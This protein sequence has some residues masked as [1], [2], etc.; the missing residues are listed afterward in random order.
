MS[1]IAS[2]LGGLGA[3]GALSGLKSPA[4]VYLG[5]LGSRTI[6]DQLIKQFDLQNLYNDKRLSDT[7]KDL[8]KRSF[9]CRKRR[10][11][12]DQC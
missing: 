6:A 2:Q 7:E 8:K 9:C 1:Q 4:D 11:D 5:I 3:F 10:L 12:H